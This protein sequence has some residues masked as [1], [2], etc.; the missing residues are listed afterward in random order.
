VVGI[1]K[2]GM[3]RCGMSSDDIQVVKQAFRILFRTNLLQK[4]AIDQLEGQ[5]GQHPLGMEILQFIRSSKRGFIGAHH[6]D[7]DTN[8]DAA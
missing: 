8:R 1:N 7:F 4:L 3:R 6:S 5:L 2:I